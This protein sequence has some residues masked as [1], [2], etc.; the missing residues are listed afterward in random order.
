MSYLLFHDTLESTLEGVQSNT[1]ASFRA[2]PYGTI[3]E[4]FAEAEKVTNVPKILDCRQFGPRCPQLPVDVGHL[5]RVPPSVK[6]PEEPED[7]FKCVNLDVV[8]PKLPSSSKLSRLPVLVWIHGGSQ[9]VT[10]GSQASGLC[11]VTKIVA[12]SVALQTPIIAVAVQYRL[13]IF[14]WGNDKGSANLSLRD[15]ALALQWVQ[16]HIAGFGGDPNQVTVGGE[17]AGAIYCH[18]HLVTGAPAK[19]YILSSGSLGLSPPQPATRVNAV[20]GMV[21]DRLKEIDP[22]LNLD[23]ASAAQIIE[24]IR[25]TGIQSWF[26]EWEDRFQGWETAPGDAQRVLLSD[27]QK[28]AVIW[29]NGVWSTSVEDIIAAFDLG[30][31]S[32]D[33][34]KELYHI[35][36]DRPSSSRIGA[37]DFV[38]DYKYLLPIE[39]LLKLFK[40]TYKEAYWALIDEANPWQPSIGSHHAIDLVL[41]FGGFNDIINEAARQS[42]SNLRQ[43]WIRFIAGGKPWIADQDSPYAFGPYGDTKEVGSLELRSRRRIAAT[44]VLNRIEGSVLDKVLG[45]LVA[46][47]ISLHN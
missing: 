19:Q 2:I 22:T 8:V 13:N 1:V 12:D 39:R 7:E 23:N 45:A 18:A 44:E 3:A 14:G 20:R 32:S 35:H 31:D 21:S 5:L 27:T 43:A 36:A 42:G 38:N 47:K 33:T 11:D 30:E 26:M 40:S 41:L 29:Q 37:L 34:L 15:Q 46:G 25:R 17:S 10:Y 24:A 9:A 28:E 4:R 6:F 16:E